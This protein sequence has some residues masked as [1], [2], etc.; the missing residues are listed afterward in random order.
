MNNKN[1]THRI[2]YYLKK[3]AE[4]GSI[5]PAK[6]QPTRYKYRNER[7]ALY[8]KLMHEKIKEAGY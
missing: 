3:V 6:K 8:K 5:H 2:A 1:V 4:K 7:L